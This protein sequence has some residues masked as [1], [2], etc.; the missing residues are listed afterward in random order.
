MFQKNADEEFYCTSCGKP[1]H[2]HNNQQIKKCFPNVSTFQKR[3]DGE[4]YCMVCDKLA[5][6]HS[7]EEVRKCAPEAITNDNE[8]GF[9][10]SMLDIEVAPAYQKNAAGEWYCL[11]CGKLKTEH[12]QEDFDICSTEST[13]DK[14]GRIVLKTREEKLRDKQHIGDQEN[15]KK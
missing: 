11:S 15:S 6:E 14:D 12:T 2:A 9:S 10:Y 4:F 8:H 13:V 7:R 1:G 5:R 3:A